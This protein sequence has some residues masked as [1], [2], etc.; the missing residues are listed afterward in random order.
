M[1]AETVRL[2]NDKT[3]VTVVT[4]ADVAGRLSGFSPEDG[5][6]R[7]RKKAEPAADA[8]ADAATE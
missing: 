6:S 7:K 2:K 3:G 5:S 4:T 1:A 8:S